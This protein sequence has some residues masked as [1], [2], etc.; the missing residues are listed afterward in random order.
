M[1]IK[2]IFCIFC[3]IVFCFLLQASGPKNGVG[4]A[5]MVMGKNHSM[6]P[7]PNDVVKYCDAIHV[8][9]TAPEN[10]NKNN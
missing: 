8:S 7:K 3:I 1:H 4:H 9:C 6:K 5:W 10:A 2:H